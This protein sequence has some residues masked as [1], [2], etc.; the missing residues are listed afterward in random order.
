MVAS[1][2]QTHKPWLPL[3]KRFEDAVGVYVRMRADE[4]RGVSTLFACV[5]LRDLKLVWGDG[6][7]W[8]RCSGV[9]KEPGCSSIEVHGDIH[10]FLVG[11]ASHPA[12]K[13]V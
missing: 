4:A 5:A 10:E 11:D 12:M 7:M 3:C 8:M 6:R 1:Q 13:D 9:R 2:P